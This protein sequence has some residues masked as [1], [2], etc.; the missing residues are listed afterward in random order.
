M[1]CAVSSWKTFILQL[2]LPNLNKN[3]ENDSQYLSLGRCF[4][5][6][7]LPRWVLFPLVQYL[8]SSEVEKWQCMGGIRSWMVG[9]WDWVLAGWMVGLDPGWMERGVR[10]WLDGTWDRVLAGWIMGLGPGWRDQILAGWI[11]GLGPGWTHVVAAALATSQGLPE[12][13]KAEHHKRL[14]MGVGQSMTLIFD[15]WIT[16]CF[17]SCAS[18]MNLFLVT[19]HLVS[20]MKSIDYRMTNLGSNKTLLPFAFL[21]SFQSCSCFSPSL[22][23]CL[24]LCISFPA[25]AAT[26]QLI[27][28][29]CL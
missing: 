28:P 22:A 10:S 15:L 18:I 16:A 27:P 3:H 6:V 17:L 25:A 7:P 2:I 14:R 21:P 13:G 24:S 11:V 5:P 26:S 19:G 4:L 1:C 23:R 8:Q 9:W 29:S 12:N 20:F